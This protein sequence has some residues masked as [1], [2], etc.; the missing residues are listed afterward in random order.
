MIDDYVLGHSA[1]RHTALWPLL[2]GTWKR[3][4]R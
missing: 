3:R 4:D 2:I 1:E